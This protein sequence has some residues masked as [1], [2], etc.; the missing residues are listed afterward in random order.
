M[1]LVLTLEASVLFILYLAPGTTPKTACNRSL[2]GPRYFRRL[3]NP[4]PLPLQSAQQPSLPRHFTIYAAHSI[5]MRPTPSLQSY[6]RISLR[7]SAIGLPTRT[8]GVLK[9]LG[10]R[11]RLST[12][13]H[14]VTQNVA[15]MIMRVKELVDVAEVVDMKTKS[16]MKELRRPDAGFYVERRKGGF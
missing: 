3:R 7:R 12:V 13:Y 6:F 11:K 14:P 1:S 16:E 5:T 10:L 8:L 4:T 9:A 15:G 2:N